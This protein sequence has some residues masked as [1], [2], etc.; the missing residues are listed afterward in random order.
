MPL[1]VMSPLVRRNPHPLDEDV[2]TSMPTGSYNPSDSVLETS[3]VVSP[4]PPARMTST[5]ATIVSTP[6]ISR[7]TSITSLSPWI[8]TLDMIISPVSSPTSPP[9][10][11]MIIPL[12]WTSGRPTPSNL[13]VYK[14]KS[15]QTT[16][17]VKSEQ[18]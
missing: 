1:L 11:P 5:L 9:P 2:V 6:K 15:N 8:Q 13:K 14:E 7:T 16:C 18:W 4:P 10:S 3:L 17:K 12:T